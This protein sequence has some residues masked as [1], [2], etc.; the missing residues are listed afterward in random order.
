MKNRTLWHSI[1]AAFGGIAYAYTHE[2]N[3]RTE[4]WFTVTAFTVLIA[5]GATRIDYILIL[6]VCALILI[7]EI[8]NTALERV[9][10]VMKPHKHPYARVIKDLSAAFVLLSG[11]FGIMIGLLVYI[12]LLLTFIQG[13]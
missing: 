12:P 3:F 6:V 7:T 2:R 8:I 1:Q 10:D 11:I 4:I 13:L 5:L 9:V